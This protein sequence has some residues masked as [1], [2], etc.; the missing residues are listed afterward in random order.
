VVEA[1]VGNSA[2]V[3]GSPTLESDDRH[4]GNAYCIIIS[5][6]SEDGGAETTNNLQEVSVPDSDEDY[7]EDVESLAPKKKPRKIYDLTR[8]F[9]LEWVCKLPWANFQGYSNKQWWVAHGEVH[10]VLYHGEVR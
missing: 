5:S 6:T 7:D 4:N 9:Q 3:A 10:N 1:P 2:A 8:K